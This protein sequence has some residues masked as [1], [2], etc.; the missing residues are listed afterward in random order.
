MDAVTKLRP[1]LTPEE[2]LELEASMARHPA[3]RQLPERQLPKSLC[4]TCGN[5]PAGTLG[6]PALA[7]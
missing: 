1:V 4:P 7:L 3:G 6:E 2:E 5:S